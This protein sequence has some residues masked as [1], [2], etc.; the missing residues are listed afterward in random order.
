MEWS[1]EAIERYKR[2][3]IPPNFS[4]FARKQT[5][6]CTRKKGIHCVTLKEVQET[7]ETYADFFGS[8]KTQEMRNLL[9]G[10]E[11]VPKMVKELFFDPSG[12]L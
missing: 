1:K 6:K 3:P 12:M 2:M 11:P 7:E 10:K 8:E 5:E 4:L 9:E